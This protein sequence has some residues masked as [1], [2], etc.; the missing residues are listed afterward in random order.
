MTYDAVVFDYDGV[1]MEPT[2]LPVLY[3]AARA[4]FRDAGVDPPVEDEVRNLAIR[5]DIEWFRNTC[6]RY[7]LDPDEFWHA[8]DTNASD[9]QIDLVERGQ[10]TLYDDHSA[11]SEIDLPRGIVSTNQQ[12]T[13]DHHLAFHDL[14]KHFHT[15][16]GRE[17]HPESLWKKKPNPY[18]LE[19]AM[20]DIGAET[21]LFVGDSTSDIEAAH[22]AGVDSV[23]INRE[24]NGPAGVE[25]TYEVET[26]HAIHN[27]ISQP[28]AA[29]D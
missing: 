2:P 5:V 6:E 8:R 7:G 20:A 11:I 29:D 1:L 28:S 13:L 12:R 10:K 22:N 16:Y 17:P 25:P 4:T 18:Y 26:L 21:A 15:V 19:Q 23:Y 14:E 9:H 27:I 24:H 3:D